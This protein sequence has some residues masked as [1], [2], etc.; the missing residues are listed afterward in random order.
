MAKKIHEEDIALNI[1]V[2]GNQAQK[3]IFELEQANRKLREET[4][5]LEKETSAMEKQ[6]TKMGKTASG[7][8]S[9]A[10]KELQLNIQLN[11][12][13]LRENSKE[14][15]QNSV[16]LRELNASLNITDMTMKQLKARAAQV[17]AMLI[18]MV[19]G[20]AAA[21]EL[22]AE[23]VQLNARMGQLN[24]LGRAQG[25]TW[26]S[27]AN[28]LNKYQTMI[29]GFAASI[30]GLVFTF[31][32]WIDYSG[33]L[34]DQQANVRKTT[35]MTK[36]EVD[37]LTRSISE[38]NTRTSRINLLE[39][40]EEGGR[41]GLAKGEIAE[42][43]EVMDKAGVAL[44]DTFTGG[45][46][47]V[48]N[49]LGKLKFL[50]AEFQGMGIDESYNAIG[51]AL[52][53][54]G[55][56]GI[57]SER[58]IAEF[59]TRVG[60]MQAALKPAAG[61]AMALGGFFEESGIQAEIASRAYNIFLSTASLKTAEFGKVMDVS[62]AE[63]EKMINANP[64][65]FFIK[66]AEALEGL[67]PE[68]T[69][70]AKILKELG[71]NANGT[72]KILGAATSGN[73]RL[74]EMIELSNQA[75]AE[76]T[77]LT[78][79]FNV[80]NENLAAVLDKVKKRVAALT[81]SQTLMEWLENAVKW[82]AKLIGATEDYDGAGK[83][84][85]NR[86]VSMIKILAV[87][88]AS[89]VSY[90]AALILTTK[91]QSALTA[92]NRIYNLVQTRTA[93]LSN[94]QRSATLLLASA[95]FFLT[96]NITR[97][98]AAM[99]LFNMTIRTNPIGLLLSA[100]TAVAGAIWYFKTRT[101]DATDSQKSFNE[102]LRDSH[103]AASEG[104]SKTIS[105]VNDL[106]TV[107]K[108][109]N[110]SLDTQ[111][112]AYQELIKINPIFN[113]LLKDEK[114]NIEGLNAAYKIYVSRLQD[115]ARA[116]ATT[117]LRQDAAED[118]VRAE[119]EL[120]AIDTQ[121]AIEE[122]KL[123]G[124]E[125]YRKSD[126]LSTSKAV[127]FEADRTSEYT[128]QLK[129]VQ[130]L[131]KEQKK[132]TDN[133][134]SA[135]I[136]ESEA[137]GYTDNRV[138][139]LNKEIATLNLKAEAYEKID[140]KIAQDIAKQTRDQI[141]H[142]E[143]V[144]AAY[145]GMSESRM[146][147][148][149]EEGD[150]DLSGDKKDKSK[151]DKEKQERERRIKELLDANKKLD[152]ELLALRRSTEDEMFK[153]QDESFRKQQDLLELNHKRKIEDL[154]R[155]LVD[156]E[157]FRAI[158]EERAKASA[159]GDTEK[160]RLLDEYK[161]LLTEKN[162]E[163][164]NAILQEELKFLYDRD[165]LNA[166]FAQKELS[167]KIADN[168]KAKQERE[169]AFNEE[170]I[171]LGSVEAIKERLKGDVSKRELA[172]IRTWED[173]KAA[174]KRQYQQ[175]DIE[176]EIAYLTELKDEMQRGLES[177]MFGDIS[178]EFMTEEEKEKILSQ[179]DDVESKILDLLRAKQELQNGQ[180]DGGLNTYGMG[181]SMDIFG[182]TPENWQVFIQNVSDGQF[183]LGEMIATVGLLQNA[184]SQYFAIVQA[185]ERRNLD[186]FNQSVEQKKRDLKR[187]LD[188]G[189]IDQEAY[190]NKIEKLEEKAELQRKKMQ[191]EAA[192]REWRMQL[193]QAFVGQSMAIINAL[194]TKPFLPTGL[195]MGSLATMMT[196]LQ[197]AAITANKPV[198]GY[199]KG[200]YPNM[201]E[202]IREQDGKPFQASYG[203]TATTGL[204]GKPTVFM[205]GEN[206]VEMIIDSKT[207]RN[208][209]PELKYDLAKQ[210]PTVRGYE[211]GFYKESNQSSTDNKM[212]LEQNL[213]VMQQNAALINML[214]ENGVQA[215]MV[216]DYAA[217]R[218]FKKV[219][220]N[221]TNH[222]N[223]NK[224]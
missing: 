3:E 20:S 161:D 174:L 132:A 123:E 14:L 187:Q 10:Y 48:A 2:N 97:A 108:S 210:T 118:V 102:S 76:G 128:K 200:L 144:K 116:K 90:R 18:N 74:R 163:I 215:Y 211:D 59:T 17:R 124:I 69:Q 49:V 103:R 51:S 110:V 70:M 7:R 13:A 22:N 107:I 40:A 133:L 196:G 85:R 191:Y 19:P 182:M 170:L 216:M 86:I 207:F 46:S 176:A 16:R 38:L 192:M 25:L 77:S 120:N 115:V 92:A 201:F 100:I 61:E 71:I 175:A 139:A 199:E 224:I 135:I 12:T 4:K 26:S 72:N 93:V 55:A 80:K 198:K 152:E 105:R 119:S 24:G 181:G 111:K 183:A 220:E 67:N 158:S 160:I 56:N 57:A 121:L 218:N 99:R 68:G 172:N 53:E 35:G 45:I 169:R 42:F 197:I 145:L 141:E 217:M 44:G 212:L 221:Y 43:V 114:F 153:I 5:F 188:T 127:N 168:Q 157:T 130:K 88:V 194:N 64:T 179:L 82:F 178:I 62:A 203:G 106:I 177:G 138:E 180:V 148:D 140:H 6:L 193:S 34:S 156:E 98:T 147:I 202:V 223:K 96:G 58:N 185:G 78:N 1:R 66:F 81:T 75:M 117:Q 165:R 206:G 37:D 162:A 21:K 204:V 54:L 36:K 84:W 83:R 142:L 149:E 222:Q 27:A 146:N 73:K 151:K 143:Q 29:V 8:T 137:T 91:W 32:R 113:G 109:Q 79:E 164:N 23:L 94:L 129:I 189:I 214:L 112:K 11:K 89:M 167:K 52:N 101:D 190:Q 15:Q 31:Q 104:I 60:S 155:T 195:A 208:F 186:L 209:T 173:A 131:Q 125:K 95:K 150:I 65:E 63:V 219:E 50:Y 126:R 9:K 159:V 213:L 87:L 33:Q 205:A 136:K 30:T 166:E 154:K 134:N 28:W 171:E 184:F 47:E 41:I 122:K 39:I